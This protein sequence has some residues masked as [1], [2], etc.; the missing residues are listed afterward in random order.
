[1]R[2]SD[3]RW[4]VA[5][6][7]GS[8]L[9]IYK[10][11]LN[12]YSLGYKSGEDEVDNSQVAAESAAMNLEVGDVVA[13]AEEVIDIMKRIITAAKRSSVVLQKERFLTK[14]SSSLSKVVYNLGKAQGYRDAGPFQGG[15][16]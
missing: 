10:A 3:S 4:K 13:G 6:D 8:N 12:E 11:L 1:M 7:Q 5:A 14:L 9:P 16:Y 2:S 15:T